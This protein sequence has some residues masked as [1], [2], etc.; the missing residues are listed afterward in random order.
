MHVNARI[1]GSSSPSYVCTCIMLLTMSDLENHK[2]QAFGHIKTIQR[3]QHVD[4]SL[5][6][7]FT[8]EGKPSITFY[9]RSITLT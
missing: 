1:P 6:A 7:C 8:T 2:T 4:M 9:K 3:Q 5:Y